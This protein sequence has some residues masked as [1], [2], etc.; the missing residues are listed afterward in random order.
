MSGYTECRR[1]LIQKP[2]EAH[3]SD[4]VGGLVVVIETGMILRQGVGRTFWVLFPFIWK[5]LSRDTHLDVVCLAGEQKQRLVLRLPPEASNSAVVTGRIHMSR[6]A[7][8]PLQSRRVRSQIVPDGRIRDALDQ[9][10]AEH[11][12]RCAKNHVTGAGKVGLTDPAPYR[13]VRTSDN[14]EDGVNLSIERVRFL[15]GLVIILVF[16]NTADSSR[17]SSIRLTDESHLPD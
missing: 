9:A 17:G 11:R 5:K 12:C 4:N 6:Y 7:Q 13:I 1:R 2:H 15:N 8:E 14:C 16:K 10:A 3:E